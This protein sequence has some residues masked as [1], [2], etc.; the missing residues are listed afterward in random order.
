MLFPLCISTSFHNASELITALATSQDVMPELASENRPDKILSQ[1]AS[2]QRKRT[3]KRHGKQPE[4][5]Y[6]IKCTVVRVMRLSAL[7]S[8]NSFCQGLS[9]NNGMLSLQRLLTEHEEKAVCWKVTHS[10][11]FWE[12]TLKKPACFFAGDRDYKWSEGNMFTAICTSMFCC[13]QNSYRSRVSSPYLLFYQYSSPIHHPVLF[14]LHSIFIKICCWIFSVRLS[15]NFGMSSI[16]EWVLELWSQ[17]CFLTLFGWRFVV[18]PSLEPEKVKRGL[19]G[20]RLRFQVKEFQ[21]LIG[22]G[23]KG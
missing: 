2:F 19:K 8:Q 14:Y 13:E 11:V 10:E 17:D 7:F 21:G 15:L 1:N 9:M 20:T 4:R 12:K 6:T 22:K 5:W 16:S 3:S 23:D 18:T